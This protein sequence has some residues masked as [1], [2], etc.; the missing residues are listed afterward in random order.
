MFEKRFNQ[1]EW[2]ILSAPNLLT[3]IVFGAIHFLISFRPSAL[4]VFFP[5]LVFGYLR[6]KQKSLAAPMLVLLEEVEEVVIHPNLVL[7]VVLEEVEWV[8]IQVLHP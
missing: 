2:K 7:M 4:L 5:G 3:N 6:E 1:W 8:Q